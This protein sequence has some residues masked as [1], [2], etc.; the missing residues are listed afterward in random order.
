MLISYITM[1]VQRSVSLQQSR[2]TY[3]KSRSNDFFV[4]SFLLIFTNLTSTLSND[5]GKYYNF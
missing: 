4:L 5:L 1:F 2:Q 3:P